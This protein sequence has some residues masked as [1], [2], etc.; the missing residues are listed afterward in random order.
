MYEKYENL[1]YKTACTNGLPGDEH[2]VF[3]HAEDTKN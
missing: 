2:M 1:P 3:E